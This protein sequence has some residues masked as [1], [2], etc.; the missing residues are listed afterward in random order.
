[1]NFWMDRELSPHYPLQYS[2]V[3][4][5]KVNANMIILGA[6]DATHGINP[7]YLETDHLR[8]FNF[9]L[10][11]AGPSF[12]LSGIREYFSLITHDLPI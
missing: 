6:C 9:S 11:G 4:H 1:M 2:E 5:P 12:T 8:V 7:R 10:N 3:F